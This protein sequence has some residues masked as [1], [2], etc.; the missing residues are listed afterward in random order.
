MD[1]EPWCLYTFVLGVE[2]SDGVHVNFDSYSV[3]FDN[4][5]GG[6][7]CLFQGQELIDRR[8][9]NLEHEVASDFIASSIEH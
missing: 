2:D 7:V 4:A 3:C 9:I 6:S 5:A 1:P 8:L